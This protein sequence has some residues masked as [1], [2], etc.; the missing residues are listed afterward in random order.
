MLKKSRLLITLAI[1]GTLLFSCNEKKAQ[2]QE[3][4]EITL[5]LAEVNPAQT[6]AGRMDQ[7][8]KEKVEELSKGKIKIDV[9]FSGVLGDNKS[10]RSIMTSR[11]ARFR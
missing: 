5:V 2:V 10:V 7:A 1:A 8:F 9:Q 11:T 3:E 4:K 6:I